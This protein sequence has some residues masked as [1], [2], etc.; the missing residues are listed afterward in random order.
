MT[1]QTL[2]HWEQDGAGGAHG[3]MILWPGT[4]REF[5]LV[6]QDFKTANML[7]TLINDATTEAFE[8][9]RRSMQADVARIVA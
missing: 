3:M 7:G 8:A 2:F 9:G 6:V 1:T 5:R 4:A